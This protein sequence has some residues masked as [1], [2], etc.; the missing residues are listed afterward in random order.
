M[1]VKQ[2]YTV[3]TIQLA[4]AIIATMIASW[5]A[6]KK[7]YQ[8][9]ERQRQREQTFMIILGTIIAILTI[10]YFMKKMKRHLS[11]KDWSWDPTPK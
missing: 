8:A 5:F 2:P 6:A 11:G 10:Q 9:K 3:W 7:V 4:A 1:S